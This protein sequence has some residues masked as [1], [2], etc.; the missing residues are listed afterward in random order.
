MKSYSNK[1]ASLIKNPII[2]FC[3]LTA[4]YLCVQIAYVTEAIS[5]DLFYIDF[6]MLFCAQLIIALVAFYSVKKRLKSS[7]RNNCIA[8]LRGAFVYGSPIILFCLLFLIPT[9]KNVITEKQSVGTLLYQF[10]ACLGIGI[11]EELLFRVLLIEGLFDVMGENSRRDS[12]ISNRTKT[13][14][15]LLSSVVFGV[16]HITNIFLI[17]ITLPDT[18][19][20][21]LYT[22]FIGI[23]LSAIYLKTHSISAVVI[24]H[25]MLDFAAI[26][27]LQYSVVNRL[28]DLLSK[29]LP[30]PIAFALPYLPFAAIGIFILQRKK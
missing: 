4:I 1:T 19:A 6:L 8:F 13:Y 17:E 28:T 11:T 15:A 10:L 22:F 7:R 9:S 20:Q 14:S 18:L 16:W 23:L 29:G 5:V 30:S 24:L 27:E 26:N 3:I 12:D 2:V 25:T 21:I